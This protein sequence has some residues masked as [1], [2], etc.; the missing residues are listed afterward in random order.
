MAINMLSWATN[1][2]LRQFAKKVIDLFR[3]GVTPDAYYRRVKNFTKEE[4]GWVKAIVREMLLEVKA[5]QQANSGNR[6]NHAAVNTKEAKAKQIAANDKELKEILAE[7]DADANGVCY[8]WIFG[9]KLKRR[10]KDT[11][12]PVPQ[13][14]KFELGESVPFTERN[15]TT[16]VKRPEDKQLPK[17]NQRNLRFMKDYKIVNKM[18]FETFK[19]RFKGNTKKVRTSNNRNSAH[20]QSEKVS[21]EDYGVGTFKAG[22]IVNSNEKG[23]GWTL[24][25]VQNKK[26]KKDKKHK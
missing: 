9:Y 21:S 18:T 19:Q 13:H 16:T 2:T 26:K 4:E 5:D 23:F 25:A 3:H 20:V 1:D 11:P 8:A 12:P 15:V 22:F 24:M 6:T 7:A 17:R 14:R 10:N